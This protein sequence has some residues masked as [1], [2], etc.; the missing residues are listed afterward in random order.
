MKIKKKDKTVNSLDFDQGGCYVMDI[1]NK[2]ILI[3]EKELYTNRFH[4]YKKEPKR[5]IDLGIMTEDLINLILKGFDEL[6]YKQ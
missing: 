2:S 4:V 1:G 3:I 6:K 5:T